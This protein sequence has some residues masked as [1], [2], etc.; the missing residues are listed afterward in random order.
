M[1]RIRHS[2]LDKLAECP[3]FEGAPAG[4]AAQR[5]I[6]M[7]SALRLLLQGDAR[8]MEPLGYAERDAVRWAA[9]KFMELAGDYAIEVRELELKMRTPGIEHVGTADVVC[10]AG[11]WVGDLKTGQIRDYY[12]QMAAY[13]WA[14]MDDNFATEWTAHLVFADQ[15]QVVTH[16]FTYEQAKEAVERIV[17]F[18]RDPWREPRACEYC[19]WCKHQD[20]CPAVVGPVT[21]TFELVEKEKGLAALRERL[22]ADPAKLGQFLAEAAIFTKELIT[23]LRDEAKKLLATNPEAVPGW[24]VSPVKGRESF[25]HVAIVQ[26][27]IASRCGMDSLVLAMGGRMAGE[28]YR[29]WCASLGQQVNESLARVGEGTTQLRQAKA[30]AKPKLKEKTQ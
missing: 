8:G 9:D 10:A 11:A 2:A 6:A 18:A 14:L 21:N 26:T 12:H 28:D 25:D 13:A 17:G 20:R 15:Q 7:D 1:N 4:P 22:L 27:A 24:K 16:K 30:S 3:C 29:A 23:P 19:G 5:G